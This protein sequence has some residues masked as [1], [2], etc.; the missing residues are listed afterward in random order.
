MKDL[1]KEFLHYSH[2]LDNLNLNFD[3]KNL[4]ILML[5]NFLFQMHYSQLNLHYYQ[6]KLM[7]IYFLIF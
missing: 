7:E 1:I 2:F 6:N 4:C 5:D 3:N